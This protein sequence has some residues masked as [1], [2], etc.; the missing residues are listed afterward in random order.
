[1]RSSEKF[2]SGTL[3]PVI[4]SSYR[5]E[6][7]AVESRLF[8][9]ASDVL[10]GAVESIRG[11]NNGAPPWLVATATRSAVMRVGTSDEVSAL[12]VERAGLELVA[13]SGV[14][15]PSVLAAKLDTE[16]PAG[17]A[18]CTGC[19]GGEVALGERADCDW[20][21]ATGPPD[22]RRGFRS[23]T[24]LGTG[25]G[26]A[27]EGRA[28]TQHLPAAEYRWF[29]A[30]R[31][32]ARQLDVERRPVDGT[33][34]LGLCRYRPRW[35]RPRIVALRRRSVFRCRSYRR[36]PA[37]WEDE[38]GHPAADVAYWDVVAALSTPPDISWFASTI[39]AQ[40]RP[41]LLREL[42]EHRR[43]RFLSDALVIVSS[44]WLC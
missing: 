10:G 12:R 21:T 25:S 4:G 34:R 13:V 35:R 36:C 20:V 39:I 1:L 19:C 31:F 37:G 42:L 43:N 40:Q 26:V 3:A 41:V 27:G 18:A 32:M 14:P 44:K 33:D 7:H 28:R 24:S 30:R 8:A 17:A 29:R 23:A 16:T 2:G 22:R 11:L 5:L 9:W 6:V 15:A 38:A